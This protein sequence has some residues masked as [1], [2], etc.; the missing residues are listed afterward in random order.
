MV[1]RGPLRADSEAWKRIE[2]GP[3]KIPT[4][5]EAWVGEASSSAG[6]TVV[7]ESEEKETSTASP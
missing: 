4:E 5:M 7:V 2:S 1:Q 6:S 3:Y